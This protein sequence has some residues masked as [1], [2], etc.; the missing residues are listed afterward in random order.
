MFQ[1]EYVFW[2]KHIPV[3]YED[4][5]K[6][7]EHPVRSDIHKLVIGWLNALNRANRHR[8]KSKPV[9]AFRLSWMRD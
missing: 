2:L 4:R 5:P 1:P 8:V 6:R 9:A 3:S 7:I